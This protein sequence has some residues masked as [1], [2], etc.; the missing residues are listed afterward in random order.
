MFVFRP[1]KWTD[2]SHCFCQ[3]KNSNWLEQIFH[4]L[5][6]YVFPNWKFWYWADLIEVTLYRPICQSWKSYTLLMIISKGPQLRVLSIIT[7]GPHSYRRSQLDIIRSLGDRIEHIELLRE[8]VLKE[9]PTFNTI[10]IFIHD[11]KPIHFKIY[12]NLSVSFRPFKITTW[13]DWS[14]FNFPSIISHN[15]SQLNLN[16]S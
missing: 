9:N 10:Q 15:H 8:K 4:I 2:Y 1:T 5:T 7:Y 3:Q 6:I 13:D 14:I 16:Y 12:I 11:H